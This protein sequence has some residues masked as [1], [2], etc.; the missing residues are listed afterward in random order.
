LKTL[1]LNLLLGTSLKIRLSNSTIVSY[2]TAIAEIDWE[3]WKI[4]SYGKFSRTSTKHV[5]KVKEL[6][7]MPV[8]ESSKKKIV[9]FYEYELGEYKMRKGAKD[10]SVDLSKY[11]LES[12]KK[13]RSLELALVDTRG[14]IKSKS[15]P[16]KTYLNELIETNIEPKDLEHIQTLLRLAKRAGDI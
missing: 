9:N 3:S 13:W 12:M 5:A 11:F 15:S 1:N 10:L 4:I 8:E 7:D 14:S 2:D 16:G 6:L